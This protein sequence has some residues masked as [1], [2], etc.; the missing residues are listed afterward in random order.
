RRLLFRS[1]S[2]PSAAD[3]GDL[4]VDDEQ[5]SMRPIV[6]ASRIRPESGVIFHHLDA[7]ALK[8][9]SI[10]QSHFARSL[11]VENQTHGNASARSFC[12]GLSELTPDLVVPENV[13][14]EI[15]RSFGRANRAQH[16]GK[17]LVAIDQS[18]D[19]V[20]ANKVWSEQRAG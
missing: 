2:D 9:L 7:G 14:L 3:E 10:F 8:L 6:V 5:F 1:I 17:N 16:R 18:S 12:Q 19:I 11:R 20:A 13:G 4:S 15:D